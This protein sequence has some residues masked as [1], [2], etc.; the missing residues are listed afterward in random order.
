MVILSLGGT[1]R[2]PGRLEAFSDAVLAIA[3]TL[4][5]VELHAPQPEEGD[6]AAAYLKLAP[7]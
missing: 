1:G 2:K 6:L 5:V 4:P 3:I 7:E